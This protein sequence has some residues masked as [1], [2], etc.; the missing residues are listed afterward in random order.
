MKAYI[1]LQ[2]NNKKH[3]I[4]I[5]DIKKLYKIYKNNRKPIPNYWSDEIERKP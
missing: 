1:T 2:Q 3:K 4:C 5:S